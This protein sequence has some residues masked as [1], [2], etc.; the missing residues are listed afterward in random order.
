[1]YSKL[2]IGV[3]PEVWIKLHI[4]CTCVSWQQKWGWS[5]ALVCCFMAGMSWMRLCEFNKELFVAINTRSSYIIAESCWKEEDSVLLSASWRALSFCWRI[6]R[7]VTPT[8]GGSVELSLTVSECITNRVW[9]SAGISWPASDG[10]QLCFHI[11][12]RHVWPQWE[13]LTLQW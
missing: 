10:K 3:K 12:W 9:T 6:K 1:M 4:W 11:M 13:S 2:V 7:E 5:E 8:Q